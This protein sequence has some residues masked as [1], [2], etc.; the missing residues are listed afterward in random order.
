LD[1]IEVKARDF[2]GDTSRRTFA[3]KR[4]YKISSTVFRGTNMLFRVQNKVS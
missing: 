2:F 4:T 3:D 1:L